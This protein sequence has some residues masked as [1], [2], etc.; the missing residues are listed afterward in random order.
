ME[1]E[2]VCLTDQNL[3]FVGRCMAATLCCVVGVCG[4]EGEG[5]GV[6][7]DS[8]DIHVAEDDDCE[9]EGVCGVSVVWC[10]GKDG[11]GGGGCGCGERD[12][13]EVGW[14]GG[15][16]RRCG[17]EDGERLHWGNCCELGKKHQ[18]GHK[19]NTAALNCRL[20]CCGS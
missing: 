19:S 14:R 8:G 3:F 9:G 10:A 12:K 6:E 20:S 18:V 11:G 1:G 7:G 5:E 17:E 15:V 2:R 13:G 4:G 16:C